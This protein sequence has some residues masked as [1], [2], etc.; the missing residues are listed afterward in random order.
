MQGGCEFI[1]DSFVITGNAVY[2]IRY[3]TEQAEH[4]FYRF[5]VRNVE[6]AFCRQFKAFFRDV[7]PYFSNAL[8]KL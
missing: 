3:F 7:V 5:L 6:L 8:K 2:D 4:Q 1:L